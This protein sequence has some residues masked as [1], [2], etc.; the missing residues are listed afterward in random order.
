MLIE[1]WHPDNNDTFDFLIRNQALEIKTTTSNDRKHHFSYE[2]LNSKNTSIIVGSV[3]IRKSRTG[4]SLLDLKNRILE[5]I[6]KKHLKEKLQENYDI[7]I[8]SKSQTDLD[9]A[10]YIYDYAADNIKFFDSK[11]VPRI[12]ETPMHGIK[13]IRFES[14]LNGIESI[15]DFSNYEF[16]K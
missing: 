3:L 4:T 14:N 5:E 12:K 16:L 1:A 9:N 2:Q 11:K 15:N 6:N 10:K 7:M 13:N 8:G